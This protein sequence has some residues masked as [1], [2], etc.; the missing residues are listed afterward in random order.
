MKKKNEPFFQ[1]EKNGGPW[2]NKILIATPST[3]IVRME[4]VMA[5]Y[6]QIIPTNWAETKII[7]WM[8]NYVPVEYL[9]PDAENLIAKAVIEGNYEWLLMIEED[10]ILPQDAFLK[11]NDYI[12]EGDVPV[13]SGLYFTKSVPPEPILYRGRGTGSYQNFKIGDKVWVDGIPFGFC[14]IHSSIIKAL[15]D[16][17]PE[18]QVGPHTTRRVFEAPDR[19]TID[20]NGMFASI[21][22]TTDLNFC[23][24]IIDNNIFEKAGWPEYQM[25]EYPFLVDTNIFLNHIDQQGRMFPL[26]GIPVKYKNDEKTKRNIQNKSKSAKKR[27]T[28]KS[29][30]R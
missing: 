8:N 25:M 2:R 14:L 17:S 20:E 9:L 23:S 29:T 18:Y 12:R 5:R 30:K 21:S 27:N 28:K 10:N 15:W 24:K 6:G 26:G 7:Q 11:I 16:E 1:M 4:W 22:G 13:V 3:G 19:A